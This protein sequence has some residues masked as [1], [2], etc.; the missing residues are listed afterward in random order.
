[1]QPKKYQLPEIRIGSVMSSPGKK[2]S[3]HL[4][5]ADK[6]ASTISI[7]ISIIQGKS[8]GPT[9]VV[10]A[11][12][13]GCEYCGIMAAIR[14]IKDTSPEKINGTLIVVPLANPPAFE[15]RT[16]FVNPIDAVNLYAS[17]PG[18]TE[19]TVSYIMAHKI[20][21]EIALKGDYLIHLHGAD[22]NESLIP[23]N[24]YALTDNSEVDS[25]SQKLASC[26]PVEYVLE[27]QHAGE[28]S[29]GSPRGTS[30]ATSASG[31][32]YGEA[33]LRGI[34]STMCESGREG[35]VEEELVR[36][37]YQG[38]MNAMKL[39]GMLQGEATLMQRQTRLFSPVLVTNR[40]AGLF[41][42]LVATGE[43]VRE[44]QN[45]GEIL[46]F[47]GE[48]V[49]TIRSPINGLVVDRIN[50]AAADAFPTQKQP[51][52]FYIAKIR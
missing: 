34:P 49:E 39:I 9:L 2:E 23:F 8:P 37:H 15:E 30:Y 47:E 33:S 10:I 38:I 41:N 48:I 24:Y 3:G 43:I 35:K 36:I 14:V 46:D 19:G 11:G 7:P 4:K 1:M 40:K 50:F 31:T 22:Y 5:V 45:I 18:S 6:A 16:L 28:V 26:F 29:A 51:Y 25:M 21:S 17:Y 20:F 32:L 13:H 44:G 52:L 27:A 42:P 12:E